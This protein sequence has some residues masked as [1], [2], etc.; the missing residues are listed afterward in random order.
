MMRRLVVVM[1]VVVCVVEDEVDE[2]DC[3][4]TGDGGVAEVEVECFD[5]D[6]INDVL[7]LL[8]AV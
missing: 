3:V 2:D 7:A 8:L 6:R 5:A 1:V 4:L